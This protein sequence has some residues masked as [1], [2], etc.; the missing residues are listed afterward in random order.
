V[1]RELPSTIREEVPTVEDLE[2]VVTKLRDE[3]KTLRRGAAG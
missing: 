2:V 1:T 3:I